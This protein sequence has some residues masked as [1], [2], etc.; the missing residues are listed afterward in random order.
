MNICPNASTG[1]QVQLTIPGTLYLT[2]GFQ[3]IC[4]WRFW[5]DILGQKVTSLDLRCR[6]Q[7]PK[8]IEY[9][10]VLMLALGQSL[11]SDWDSNTGSTCPQVS[12]QSVE[13]N[14]FDCYISGPSVSILSSL[15]RT[16]EPQNRIYFPLTLEMVTLACQY[17]C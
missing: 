8:G 12:Q 10:C 6:K 3:I 4:I 16:V 14:A 17:I 7:L 11:D 13:D 1:T 15:L 9:D 2:S 5:S